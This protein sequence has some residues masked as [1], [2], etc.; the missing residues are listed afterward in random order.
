MTA[1]QVV[2]ERNPA[3]PSTDGAPSRF[4]DYVRALL[5]GE[6]PVVDGVGSGSDQ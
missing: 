1:E 3:D 4:L 6:D 2:V 5:A